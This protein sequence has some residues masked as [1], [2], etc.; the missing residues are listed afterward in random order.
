MKKVIIML[1]AAQE[2]KAARDAAIKESVKTA[3]AS[4]KFKINVTSVTPMRATI[5]TT[6]D[7]SLPRKN[8]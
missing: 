4:Q 3:V 6:R 7:T 1:M 5:S 2:E 8:K